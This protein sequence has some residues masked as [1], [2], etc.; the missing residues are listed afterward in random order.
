MAIKVLMKGLTTIIGCIDI[1]IA[2]LLDG[3]GVSDQDWM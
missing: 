3:I 2:V 1:I